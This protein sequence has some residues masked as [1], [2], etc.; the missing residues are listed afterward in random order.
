MK[1]NETCVSLAEKKFFESQNEKALHPID[2]CEVVMDAADN[3]DGLYLIRCLATEYELGVSSASG[4]TQEIHT[5]SLSEILQVNL[6]EAGFLDRDITF[7]EW[8]RERDF[9][10]VKTE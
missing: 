1:I 9:R 3:E 7:L 10:G 2:G 5:F 6:R 4:L 8:L